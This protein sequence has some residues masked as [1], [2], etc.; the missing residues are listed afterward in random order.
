MSWIYSGECF[1]RAKKTNCFN[2]QNREKIIE[3]TELSKSFIMGESVI[4]VLKTVNFTL[5]ESEVVSIIGA[6]GTGKSTLLHILGLLDTSDSGTI[7]YDG[8]NIQNLSDEKD[9]KSVV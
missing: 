3:A 1:L 4:N 5:F 9:R 8:N 7:L 6:S 2:L